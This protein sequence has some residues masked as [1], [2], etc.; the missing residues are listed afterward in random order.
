MA[1]VTNDA[2]LVVCDVLGVQ[3]LPTV[4]DVGPRQ[5][6][7]ADFADARAQA[8]LALRDAGLVDAYDDVDADLGAALYILAAPEREIAAR[9]V[10]ETGVRRICLARRGAGHA[11][12]VREGD[13]LDI[14]TTWAEEDGAALA[15]PILAALGACPPADIPTFSLPADELARRFDGAESG[16]DFTGVPYELGVTDKAAIEFGMAM[17][18]CRAH[19]EIVAY[20]H[21]DGVTTRSS[22]AVAVFDTARGRIAASPGTAADLR[23]WTTVTPG[24]DHRVAQAISQLVGTLPGGRWMP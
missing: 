5:D 20:L 22:G 19:A 15:R 7:V 16:P 12:A 13:D 9:V 4:L 8:L 14:T 17:A 10:T 1:A 2:V 23:V 11:I 18:E 24:S 6:R 21:E 3:T